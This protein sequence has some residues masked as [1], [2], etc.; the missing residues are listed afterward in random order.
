MIFTGR[1]FIELR[2]READ[3]FAVEAAHARGIERRKVEAAAR[4]QVPRSLK[5]RRMCREQLRPLLPDKGRGSCRG[6]RQIGIVLVAQ[7]RVLREEALRPFE[8]IGRLSA[9]G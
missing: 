4:L 9:A 7:N 1:K 5:Q 6:V 2:S 3:L 8:Q